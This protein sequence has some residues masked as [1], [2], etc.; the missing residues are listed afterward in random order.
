VFCAG[1]V[2]RPQFLPLF[3]PPPFI[4]GDGAH[5]NRHGPP[6]PILSLPLLPSPFP[7]F[8]SP[9]AR[10]SPACYKISPRD[11]FF[12]FRNTTARQAINSAGAWGDAP[13]GQ[14]RNIERLPVY[15]LFPFPPPPP[16]PSLLQNGTK[17]VAQGSRWGFRRPRRRTNQPAAPPLLPLFLFFPF[18]SRSTSNTWANSAARIHIPLRAC[19]KY[20]ASFCPLPFPFFFLMPIY[21]DRL[22]LQAPNQFRRQT[23]PRLTS[24]PFPFL[25][26]SLPQE[27][28]LLDH[29]LLSSSR[30]TTQ[31]CKTAHFGPPSRPPPPPFS[32]P[33]EPRVLVQEKVDIAND[34]HVRSLGRYLLPTP[35]T[36]SLFP[37][38]RSSSNRLPPVNHMGCSNENGRCSV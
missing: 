29:R 2:F 8:F 25:P 15:Y 38:P 13:H 31:N 21:G 7:F 24:P 22:L 26:L 18:S 27:Y 37:P 9:A 16:L 4:K 14:L 1:A 6:N 19:R 20:S 33:F 28:E 10:P 23:I 35:L 30:S 34:T 17:E 36:S 32:F 5:G 12:L 11:F 3:P